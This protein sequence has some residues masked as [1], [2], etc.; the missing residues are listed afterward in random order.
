MKLRLAAALTIA[1][2]SLMVPPLVFGKSSSSAN[3]RGPSP[4]GGHQ[5]SSPGTT[6]ATSSNVP[7]APKTWDLMMPPLAPAN[8]LVVMDPDASLGKWSIIAS[9]STEPACE[10]GK[11]IT[12]SIPAKCIAS[13]DQR[14][15]PSKN[16]R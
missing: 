6:A 10:A 14:L 11:A 15:K 3:S 16:T 5:P 1:G 4:D 8:S 12:P 7:Y 2:W 13:D 9:Y